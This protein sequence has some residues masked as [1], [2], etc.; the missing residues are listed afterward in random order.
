MQRY[1]PM[2]CMVTQI[3]IKIARTSRWAILLKWRILPIR[4]SINSFP[5]FIDGVLPEYNRYKSAE[6]RYSGLSRAVLFLY[7]REC[8]WR[9]H[10]NRLY[11]RLSNGYW[12]FM[13]KLFEYSW[14][15]FISFVR[16]FSPNCV[17]HRKI[18]LR[19]SHDEHNES[20]LES[21]FELI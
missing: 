5:F 14:P 21:S 8:Y 10:Y 12:K 16:I 11:Y 15:E 13:N 1:S 17:H 4:S 7:V 2:N 9:P 3:E 20:L 19:L 18:Y 6:A